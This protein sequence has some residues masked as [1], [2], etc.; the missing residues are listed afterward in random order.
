MLESIVDPALE[1]LAVKV[2]IVAS[3]VLPLNPNSCC[4]WISKTIS[5]NV[6]K[7]LFRREKVDILSKIVKDYSNFDKKVEKYISS[8]PVDYSTFNFKKKIDKDQRE[9]LVSVISKQYK[10][11]NF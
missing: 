6:F 8:F 4:D 11:T 9:N 7:L 5:L 10:K 1:P 2:A 3:D